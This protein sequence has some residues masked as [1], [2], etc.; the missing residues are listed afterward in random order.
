MTRA[1]RWLLSFVRS[2]PGKSFSGLRAG[3]GWPRGALIDALAVLY[4]RGLIVVW[5]VPEL[6]WGTVAHRVWAV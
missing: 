6:E 3:L 5:P 4:H 1:A 2:T